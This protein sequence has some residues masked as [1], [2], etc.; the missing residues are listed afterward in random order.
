MDFNYI[1]E[2]IKDSSFSNE[3]FKHSYINNLF[4]DDHFKEITGSSEINIHNL[5]NDHDLFEKL[6]ENQYKI[7]E[8]PGTV[9]NQ[10]QYIEWH[11]QKNNTQIVHSACEGFGIVLRLM[12]PQSQIILEL[13]E[14]LSSKEFQNTLAEKYGVDLDKCNYDAG[15]QKYLDGYEISPHPDIRR[16]ALT[17]MVNINPHP[18]AESEKIHT[19]YLKLT[20]NY[21]YVSQFWEGN[22][23]VDRSWVPWS[24]CRVEREQVENNSMVI[25]SPSNDTLHAVKADYNHLDFQRTQMY[26]NFWYKNTEQ[27]ELCPWENLVIKSYV[28]TPKKPKYQTIKKLLPQGLVN[29]IRKVKN[30]SKENLGKREF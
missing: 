5:K 21:E 8:F 6:Y 20:K 17:Y 18:Q 14:F 30:R 13:N 11:Q 25:F 1:L 9:T 29:T 28:P 23:K 4:K 10:K 16:K 7:I 12:K 15:I 27:V 19:K 22:P 26:G 24:W 2:K 3:P